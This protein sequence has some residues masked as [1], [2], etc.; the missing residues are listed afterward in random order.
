VP[1][2]VRLLLIVVVPVPAPIE[3]AVAASPKSIEVAPVLKIF[4]VVS[5]VVISPPLTAILPAVVIF[6]EEPVILKFVAVYDGR[7]PLRS[8]NPKPKD[9]KGWHKSY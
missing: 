9:K 5:V 3:I 2:T 8:G 1:L 6:P 4:A 7:T